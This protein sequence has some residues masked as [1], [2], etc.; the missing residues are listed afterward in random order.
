M[1]QLFAYLAIPL[2]L[3]LS[4]SIDGQ[5]AQGDAQDTDTRAIIKASFL[6]NFGVQCDWPDEAKKGRFEI[7]VLGNDAVYRALADT[8]VGKPVGS[9]V[10]EVVK[11]G[12]LSEI[13]KPNILYVAADSLEELEPACDLLEEKSVMVVCEQPDA[14]SKGATINFVV[15]SSKIRYEL[16]T[17]QA[18]SKGITFGTIILQWAVQK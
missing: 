18:A 9:Q 4:P 15:D 14:M 5:H 10:V 13:E 11:Y 3:M 12:E 6:Y 17:E 2:C 16:N 7:A 1:T 8:Y